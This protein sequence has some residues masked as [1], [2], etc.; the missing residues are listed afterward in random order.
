MQ[1]DYIN[2]FIRSLRNTFQ[3]MLTCDVHRGQLSMGLECAPRDGVSGVIGLSGKAVGT[4]VLNMSPQVAVKAASAMLA[5]E[6]T[7]VDADVV[8]AVGELT[9]I[10]AGNAKA[11]LEQYDLRVSLPNVVTGTDHSFHFPSNVV[12]FCVPFT[13]PWG[14]ISLVVGLVA[15]QEPVCVG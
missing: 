14:P 13:S 8:D 1:A 9:N 11:Q 12:P 15:V 10:I 3:A 2:P 4:V 7:E 5:E 6:M